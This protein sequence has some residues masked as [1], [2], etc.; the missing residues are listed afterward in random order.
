VASSTSQAGTAPPPAASLGQWLAYIERL[1]ARPIELGLERVALVAQ[2]LDLHLT[3]PVITVGGTNGK[4]STCAFLEAMLAAAGYRVATYTSPHLVHFN[5]RA[6]LGGAA[7]S[8]E[9]LVAQLERVEAARGEVSLTY[10][11]FTTLAILAL[12]QQEGPDAVIL[13]VGLGGR[14]DAVNVI[15]PDCA[16]VTCIAI[17][18]EAFL[19]DTRET[20]GWEKAHIF[21]PGRPALCVDEQPPASLTDHAARIGAPLQLI[22]RDFG[23]A[24]QGET[25]SCWGAG[26]RHDHLPLPELRGT[27]QLAN[28]T[29]AIAALEALGAAASRDRSAA[30]PHCDRVALERGLRAARLAGRFQV[31]ASAPVVVLDVAHNPHASAQLARNLAEQGCAGATMAVFG[32]MADKDLA[33]VLAPLLSRISRW[34]VVELPGDRAAPAAALAQE[35][36]TQAGGV[37]ALLPGADHHSGG[38]AQVAIS[39]HPSPRAGLA[40][41]RQV[42]GPDDRIVVFG[43]FLTVADILAER[44]LSSDADAN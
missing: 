43:S 40:A 11:E 15:D 5:E 29:G 35:I 25:W 22:G 2:R 44:E 21:R 8:D 33:G 24:V 3:S 36:V 23:F 6:R 1:H 13:E 28:A 38:N 26:W 16:I 37:G 14:L 7:V 31:L 18:H 12:F 39:T 42:A 41:A 30:H 10:F 20:I 34:F 27:N 4:G 32:I 17:D 9:M 19:G